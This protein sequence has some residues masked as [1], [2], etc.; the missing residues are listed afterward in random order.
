MRHTELWG[1]LETALGPDAAKTW[2]EY[3]A[4]TA[5]GSRTVNEALADGVPPKQV[6]LEVWTVLELPAR[7]K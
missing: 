7:D 1:R 6:W 3:Q 2:A 4:I 5:L